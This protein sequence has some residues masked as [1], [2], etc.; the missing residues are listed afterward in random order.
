M[1]HYD[2]H[3]LKA[4]GMAL[5]QRVKALGLAVAR[6]FRRLTFKQRVWLGVGAVV[7]VAGLWLLLRARPEPPQLPVVAAEPIQIK[8]MEV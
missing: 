3:H 6:W 5:I 2:W 1:Q 4:R 7:L 8:D